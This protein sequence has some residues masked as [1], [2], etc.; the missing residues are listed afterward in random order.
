[1]RSLV[2]KMELKVWVQANWKW[3]SFE[4]F[5]ELWENGLQL[6][7]MC[8]EAA[9]WLPNCLYRHEVFVADTML[10]SKSQPKNSC[11]AASKIHTCFRLSSIWWEVRYS[12]L[13]TQAPY[14]VEAVSS[15]AGQR[16]Q[17]ASVL[18]GEPSPPSA[19]S[20]YHSVRPYTQP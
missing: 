20:S 2:S 17:P 8:S 16:P 12:Y 9:H 10:L 1:M 4:G 14:R 15:I 19:A 18:W 5:Q 7:W 3:G 6:C 11:K 13:F